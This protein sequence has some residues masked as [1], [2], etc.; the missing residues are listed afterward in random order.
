MSVKQKMIE[1]R[2]GRLQG[3]SKRFCRSPVGYLTVRFDEYFVE[4]EVVRSH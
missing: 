2:E 3:F 1:R 4:T